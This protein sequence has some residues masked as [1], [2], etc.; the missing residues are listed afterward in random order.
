MHRLIVADRVVRCR[1]PEPG[2]R[3]PKA[4]WVIHTADCRFA[5]G[6]DPLAD[7]VTRFGEGGVVHRVRKGLIARCATCRPTIVERITEEGT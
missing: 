6:C 2:V 4:L 1:R 3:A 5:P 7:L